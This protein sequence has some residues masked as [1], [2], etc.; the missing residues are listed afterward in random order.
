M[1]AGAVSDPAYG[2]TAAR[3]RIQHAS[4]DHL[5]RVDHFRLDH[6]EHGRFQPVAAVIALVYVASLA[7]APFLPE[8][9]GKPLPV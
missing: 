7:L 3:F 5:A 8:T 1:V 9:K 6:R 4:P 2:A